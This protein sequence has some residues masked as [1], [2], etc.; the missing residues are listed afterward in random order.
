MW[1]MHG[2]PPHLPGSTVIRDGEGGVAMPQAYAVVRRPVNP[3]RYLCIPAQKPRFREGWQEASGRPCGPESHAER[4]WGRASPTARQAVAE[5]C[6]ALRHRCL[7]QSS[8]ERGPPT[9]LLDHRKHASDERQGATA[10]GG[11]D[12]GDGGGGVGVRHNDIPVGTHR[13]TGDSRVVKIIV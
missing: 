4:P 12:L 5:E 2:R 8:D 7:D 10:R 9:A 13:A 1:R 11:I 3:R 6:G